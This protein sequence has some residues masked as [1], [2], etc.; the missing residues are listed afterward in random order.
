[1]FKLVMN[2]NEKFSLN[3]THTQHPS[4]GAAKTAISYAVYHPQMSSVGNQN[5]LFIS[6][7]NGVM[8]KWN[9]N[10]FQGN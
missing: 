5:S 7:E 2:M 6:C 3:S 8:M 4:A 10:R 1:M 9:D